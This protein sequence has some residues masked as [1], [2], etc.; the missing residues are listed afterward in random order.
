MAKDF[1]MDGKTRER[2][3]GSDLASVTEDRRGKARASP[4]VERGSRTLKK[5]GEKVGRKNNEFG[6]HL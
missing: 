1:F 6:P 3:L 4:A 5:R 2:H